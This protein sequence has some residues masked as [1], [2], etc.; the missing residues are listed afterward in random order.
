[1]KDGIKRGAGFVIGCYL[2]ALVVSFTDDFFKY[3]SKNKKQ[4]STSENKD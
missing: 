4:Y 2:G 3:I 1:M